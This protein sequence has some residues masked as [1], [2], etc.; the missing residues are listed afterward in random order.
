LGDFLVFKSFLI[1]ESD[2]CLIGTFGFSG[3]PIS[4]SNLSNAFVVSNFFFSLAFASASCIYCFYRFTLSSALDFDCVVKLLFS[5]FA[6]LIFILI[7]SFGTGTVV[8]AVY[9]YIL[10]SAGASVSD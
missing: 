9:I 2:F 7:S 8:S 1:Y 4:L 6:L 3:A 5:S 10:S